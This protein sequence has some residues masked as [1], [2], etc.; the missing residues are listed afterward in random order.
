MPAHFDS[1]GQ[2]TA[3]GLGAIVAGGIPRAFQK[4]G[5]A[6]ANFSCLTCTEINAIRELDGIAPLKQ[7]G[8]AARKSVTTQGNIA[9]AEST[10][11]LAQAEAASQRIGEGDSELERRGTTSLYSMPDSHPTKVFLELLGDTWANKYMVLLNWSRTIPPFY[12]RRRMGRCKS[13]QKTAAR[14]FD[15]L[16]NTLEKAGC[17][18]RKWT[19]HATKNYEVRITEKGM[20]RLKALG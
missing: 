7:S 8:L 12:F 10:P 5:D 13:S 11:M 18:E 16:V 3:S 9:S 6:L 14:L 15:S 1:A 4:L 2:I 17:I 20:R 19:N